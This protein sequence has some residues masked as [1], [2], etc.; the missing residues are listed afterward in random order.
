M[1]K[2]DF[3]KVACQS[4]ISIMLQ[5]NFLCEFA[6]YFQNNFFLEH[7]WVAASVYPQWGR[8]GSNDLTLSWQRSKLYRNQS[9]YLL[10]KSIDWFPYD[11]HFRH[12]S[13]KGA[14]SGLRQ[15][16]ATEKPLKKPFFNFKIFKFLSWL[17]SHVE[18]TNWLERKS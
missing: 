10:N 5:S 1:P 12:E 13:I 17:F 14:F 3:N 7:L 11:R 8:W 6:A 18:P 2:C 15:Y 9:I 16:L 4:V